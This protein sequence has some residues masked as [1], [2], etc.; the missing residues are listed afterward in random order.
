MTDIVNGIQTIVNVKG[1]HNHT[2]VLQR[3]KRDRE[4][5]LHASMKIEHNMTMEEYDDEDY[6]DDELML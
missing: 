5:Y 6:M 1:E 4:S 3:K 2:T